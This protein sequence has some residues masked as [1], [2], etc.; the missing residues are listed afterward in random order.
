MYKTTITEIG[1]LVPDFQEERLLI[2]FGPKAT[3]ELR[4]ISVIHDHVDVKKNV[5]VKGGKLT[6]AG[7][8][9]II[10]EVGSAANA[11]FNELGHVSIYF[12]DGENE[13]LPGAI[14]A[15]PNEWPDFKVGEE[16]IFSNK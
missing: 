2:L 4:S 12:R 9:Y 5:I 8:E 10:G 15:K 14:I 13:V 6:I 3:P 16:I 11:N 7:K 1:D